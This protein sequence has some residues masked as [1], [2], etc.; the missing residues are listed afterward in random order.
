[1]LLFPSQGEPQE[2]LVI[3][4]PHLAPPLA[5]VFGPQDAADFAQRE[6]HGKG[7]SVKQSCNRLIYEAVRERNC[8][9]NCTVMLVRFDG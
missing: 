4:L 1:L 7:N 2:P 3:P 8:K 5:G 9:D 6:L